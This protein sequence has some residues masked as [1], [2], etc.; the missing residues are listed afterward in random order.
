MRVAYRERRDALV[1]ALAHYL[2]GARVRGIAAGLQAVVD[3]PPSADEQR[4]IAAA[5]RRGVGVYGMSRFRARPNAAPPSLVLGYA[6]LSPAEIT[7]GIAELAAAI[8]ET[9]RS[10]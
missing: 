2:P 1:R 6:A 10:R 3:L 4:I 9:A 7:A 8:A 5:N